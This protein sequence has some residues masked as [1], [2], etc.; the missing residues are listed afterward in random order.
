MRTDP[1]TTRTLAREFLG[2]WRAKLWHFVTD[3]VRRALIDSLVM[4]HVQL[5]HAVDNQAPVT[6]AELI[7]FRGALIA[8]LAAGIPRSSAG[9][10]HFTL[11]GDS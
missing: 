8:T 4:E 9:R 11:S 1:G 6:P 2:S 3:D 10:V 5:A 7:E